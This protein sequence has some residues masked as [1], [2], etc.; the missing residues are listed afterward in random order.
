MRKIVL[1]PAEVLRQKTKEIKEVDKKLLLEI[2]DLQK[3]LKNQENGA[4][5]AAPQIGISKRFFGSKEMGNKE[6]VLVFINPKIVKIYGEKVYPKLVDENGKEDDFLEGCLS[7]PSFFGTVKRFLKIEVAYF[8]IEKGKLVQKNKI[9]SGFEAIV[10][11]H[12]SDHL[13]GIVFIDHT[14][15]EDGKFYKEVVGKMEKAEISN[16]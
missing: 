3:I 11:Q 4:G 8:E 10:W 16:F 6:S 2:K 1:Y 5:L 14:K 7:F 15:E 13:D 12:E 9:L